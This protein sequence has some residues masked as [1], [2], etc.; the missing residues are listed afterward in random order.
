VS[1]PQPPEYYEIRVAGVLDDRW[2]TWFEGLQIRAEGTETVISG[3]LPDQPALHGVLVRVGDLGM[4]LIS[5]RRVS[6]GG[7][8]A[9]T[10][11][12]AAP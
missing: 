9:G 11:S 7:T 8:E 3:P 6:P 12:G 1:T 10:E 4:R 2:T 5:V